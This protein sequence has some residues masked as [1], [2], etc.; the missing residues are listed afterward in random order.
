[1]TQNT[2]NNILKVC[3]KTSKFTDTPMWQFPNSGVTIKKWLSSIK[4]SV[5]WAASTFAMDAGIH[6]IIDWL[7][8]KKMDFGMVNNS[9]TTD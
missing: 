4:K 9:I 2:F 8:N 3:T 5:S 6:K 1:M 7:N